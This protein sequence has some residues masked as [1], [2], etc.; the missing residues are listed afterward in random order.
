MNWLAAVL[1]LAK[2]RDLWLDVPSVVARRT[3][4]CVHCASALLSAN[5]VKLEGLHGIGAKKWLAKEIAPTSFLLALGKKDR[6]LLPA[7]CDLAMGKGQSLKMKILTDPAFF[8][9]AVAEFPTAAR[10]A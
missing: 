1:V 2:K 8:G 5:T 10:N 6:E 7:R 3:A 9:G 4:N